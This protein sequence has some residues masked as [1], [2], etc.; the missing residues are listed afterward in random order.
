MSLVHIFI[1]A[2]AAINFSEI[3]DSEILDRDSATTIVL[4]NLVLS[5]KGTTSINRSRLAG[6]LKLDGKGIFADGGP[7]YVGQC[8]SSLAVHAFFLAGP[9]DHVG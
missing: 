9:D 7:L 4:D 1:V 5:A 6:I 3:G 8:A 2:T